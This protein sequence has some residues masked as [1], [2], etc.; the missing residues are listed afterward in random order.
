M[1]GLKT[2]A[3]KSVQLARYSWR[4]RDE[5][6]GI[7]LKQESGSSDGTL[8]YRLTSE[9]D[10]VEFPANYNSEVI[11][12][13]ADDMSPVTSLLRW[14]LPKYA[15]DTIFRYGPREEDVAPLRQHLTEA[16]VQHQSTGHPRESVAVKVEFGGWRY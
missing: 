2:M 3:F 14:Y 7:E 8:Y 13:E 5:E 4:V 10:D 9:A 11:Q 1:W 15:P 16:F 12:K 6:R